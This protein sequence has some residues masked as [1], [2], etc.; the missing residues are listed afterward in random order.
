MDANELMRKITHLETEVTEHRMRS[1]AFK[2]NFDR[3]KVEHSQ[4]NEENERL[5]KEIS[6]S[7]EIH[8]SGEDRLQQLIARERREKEVAMAECDELRSQIITPHR[9]E[10]IKHQLVE[11]LERT[12]KERTDMVERELEV[13]KSKFNQL[14][15]DCSFLES[16]LN[17][18]AKEH[19][20]VVSDLQARHKIEIET[21]VKEKREWLAKKEVEMPL[22]I[23]K[24]RTLQRENTQLHARVKG[25]LSELEELN[26]QRE[27]YS[28]QA[29]QVS[30][31]QA[32]ELADCQAMCKALEIERETA[33]L[34]CQRLQ[35]QVNKGLEDQE[36]LASRVHELEKDNLSLKSRLDE[37]DHSHR[38]EQSNLKLSLLQSRGEIERERDALMTEVESSRTKIEVL[39]RAVDDM[40]T[41]IA[42]K[43]NDVSRRVQ[44][45]VDEELQQYTELEQEKLQLEAHVAEIERARAEDITSHQSELGQL[46]DRVRTAESAKE[47]IEKENIQL[48][49]QVQREKRRGGDLEAE[50]VRC[51]ELQQKLQ[52]FQ[53]KYQN[54]VASENECQSINDKLK[55]RLEL[56]NEEL[57]QTHSNVRRQDEENAMVAD[58]QKLA[59]EQERRELTKRMEE[60]E[61]QRLAMSE[62]LQKA[63]ADVKRTQQR[64]RRKIAQARQDAEVVEARS[65]QLEVEK[66]ADKQQLE[67]ENNKLRRQLREFHRKQSEFAFL[68]HN[69]AEQSGILST[70]PA[71]ASFPLAMPTAYT[72]IIA[73]E[74]K[75]QKELAEVRERIE[76]LSSAADDT[77]HTASEASRAEA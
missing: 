19:S 62:R 53:T 69:G 38:V 47:S 28:L 30:H 51:Q 15:Y 71:I 22:E 48:K 66:K 39:Q 58:R 20:A 1:D 60:C 23:Q 10:L 17:N 6:E 16:E 57:R 8:R 14:R 24:L 36:K 21:M 43:E 49:S 18:Q 40:T 42:D 54:V 37:A 33:Q 64:Y 73:Q 34:Q 13:Y 52:Q 29:E 44:V 25:L 31:V 12:Y 75:N 4:L 63:R 76:R 55:S 27:S 67:A 2:T 3:L 50:R 45:A 59:W 74:K 26:E 9:L 65:A 41:R 56:M 72:D 35:D 32:R 7:R 5:Q 70:M 77:S 61:Q 46:E 68:L 11:N